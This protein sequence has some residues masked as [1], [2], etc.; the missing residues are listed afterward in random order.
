MNDNTKDYYDIPA[1]WIPSSNFAN[2]PTSEI[3]DINLVDGLWTFVYSSGSSSSSSEAEDNTTPTKSRDAAKESKSDSGALPELETAVTSQRNEP[4][5]RLRSLSND[6]KMIERPRLRRKANTAPPGT[7][8]VPQYAPHPPRRAISARP[9]AFRGR[10]KQQASRVA[11]RL[12]FG[13]TRDDDLKKPREQIPPQ[14]RLE[15]QG[16]NNQ[17]PEDTRLPG[18]FSGKARVRETLDK[19]K[20]VR[21]KTDIVDFESQGLLSS[22]MSMLNTP[23]EMYA[24]PEQHPTSEEPSSPCSP[25]AKNARRSILSSLAGT[26]PTLH[27]IKTRQH[28]SMHDCHIRMSDLAARQ[29]IYVAGAIC[30]EEHAPKLRKDSVASLDPFTKAGE[31]DDRRNC[32]MLVVDSIT[33]FFDDLGVMEGA[34]EE[35]L[36]RYWH[37]A[38]RAPR[39]IANARM[40]IMIITS[41][42]EAPVTS[43]TTPQR[44]RSPQ[45][46]GSRFSFSSASSSSSLAARSGTPMRQ[47]DKLKRLLSPAFP[48]SGFRRTPAD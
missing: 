33:S 3:S 18:S 5:P 35:C 11:H 34:T 31:S 22:P 43:V 48:G 10:D 24:I 1:E 44:G 20:M 47:R 26:S 7:L 46:Q 4:Q 12:D 42:Q 19:K 15:T 39:H 16:D 30:L 17:T 8:S 41:M 2:R 27:L 38:Y 28:T 13:K 6:V 32:D 29:P 37:D 36:D 21:L 40:S 25:P 9:R 45:G 14:A 23:R